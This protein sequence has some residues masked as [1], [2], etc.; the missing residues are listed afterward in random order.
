MSIPY[1][2]C[3]RWDADGKEECLLCMGD[4]LLGEESVHEYV[5][6]PLITQDSTDQSPNNAQSLSLSKGL[7]IS[8]SDDENAHMFTL[9]TH[10]GYHHLPVRLS[11]AL[12]IF[13]ELNICWQGPQALLPITHAWHGQFPTGT[14]STVINSILSSLPKLMCH[15]MSLGNL[16]YFRRLHLI[17]PST[18]S[19]KPV[20]LLTVGTIL[21]IQQSQPS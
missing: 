5:A 12:L 21:P 15:V 11:L 16:I 1:N 10:T 14:W 3:I 2:L 7:V 9:I 19:M 18:W 6:V 17:C 4:R 8:M 20:L 13:V